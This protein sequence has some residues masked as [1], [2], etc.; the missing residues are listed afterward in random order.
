MRN[1]GEKLKLGLCEF[2][3]LFFLKFFLC[4]RSTQLQSG[5]PVFQ[6]HISNRSHDTYINK[7]SQPSRPPRRMNYDGQFNGMRVIKWALL[8]FAYDKF[9]YTGI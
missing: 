8:L 5:S 1:V 4:Q 9:I 3:I 6:K 7:I 2:L